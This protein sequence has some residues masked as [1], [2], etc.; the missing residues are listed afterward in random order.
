MEKLEHYR[1]LIKQQIR[2]YVESFSEGANSDVQELEVFDDE[3]GRA[4]PM[5]FVGM[6]KWETRLLHTSLCPVT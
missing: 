1:D 3:R 4:L 5:G 6:G 2:R